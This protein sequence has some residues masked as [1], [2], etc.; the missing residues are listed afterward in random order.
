MLFDEED[1][2]G[3]I[4]SASDELDGSGGPKADT[5]AVGCFQQARTVGSV[6]MWCSSGTVRLRR[7]LRK[8]QG[9]R[10]LPSGRSAQKYC[11]REGILKLRGAVSTARSFCALKLPPNQHF[12]QHRRR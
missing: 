11:P 4:K 6:V 12:D 7:A 1:R 8:R 5:R 10:P 3:K 9:Q 2:R